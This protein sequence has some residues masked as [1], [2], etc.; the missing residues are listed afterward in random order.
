MENK[1]EN[2]K[3]AARSDSGV[4]VL[5]FKKP[6]KFDENTYTVLTFDFNKLKGEDYL[7]IEREMFDLGELRFY[8]ASSDPHFLTRL[9]AKAGNVSRDVITNLDIA[10]FSAIQEAARRFLTFTE[11]ADE[12]ESI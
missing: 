8:K 3:T 1:A 5:E 10:K 11:S 12:S 4:F 7:D 6:Y 9:A 2:K